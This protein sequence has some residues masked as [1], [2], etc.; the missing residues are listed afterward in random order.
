M[1]NLSVVR[2]SLA[3]GLVTGFAG[4]PMGAQ[5]LV[6]VP[7]VGSVPP[8]TAATGTHRSTASAAAGFDWG[9]AGIGAGGAIVV[10]VV[11]VAGAGAWRRQGPI[12]AA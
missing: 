3:L 11:G 9:D 1:S 8:G 5:A 7:Y 12:G 2:R 6:R 4:F 10:L